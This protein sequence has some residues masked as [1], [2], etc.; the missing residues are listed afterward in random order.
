MGK[1]LVAY[2][3][4]SGVTRKAAENLAQAAG[5]DLYE[6][7]EAFGKWWQCR[8]T[9]NIYLIS[10]NY[11]SAVLEWGCLLLAIWIATEIHTGTEQN[12][13]L[14]AELLQKKCKVENLL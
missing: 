4:A 10:N 12:L 11:S 8:L 2:F 6:I 9:R 14:L 7:I 13:A 3:S 1:T 5:A